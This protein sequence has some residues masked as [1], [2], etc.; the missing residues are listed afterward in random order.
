LV[1]VSRT[2]TSR[3]PASGSANVKM[4]AVPARA[5]IVDALGVPTGGTDRY[6]SP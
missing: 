3:Q 5:L 4:F 1:I 6:L 2:A